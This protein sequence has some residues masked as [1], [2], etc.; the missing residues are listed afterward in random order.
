M[1]QQ[2]SPNALT[3]RMFS[4]KTLGQYMTPDHVADFIAAQL[5]PDLE[6]V[7]DLAAG[8]CALLAAVLAR[9]PATRVCGFE[10]D[11]RIFAASMDAFPDANLINGDGL[12]T[13]LRKFKLTSQRIAVVGNPPFTEITPPPSACS[14]VREAFPRTA[15][16][17]GAKR[18]ELYFLA[19]SLLIAKPSKGS[20]AIVMPAG[21]AD[22]DICTQ[23]RRSL[24]KNYAVRRAIEFPAQ[25]FTATEARAILLVIDT[26]EA[27]S[28]DI[29]IG[30]YDLQKRKQI[31]IYRGQLEPGE[32]LDARFHEGRLCVPQN[33]PTIADMGVTVVRGRVSRKEA[34]DLKL[35]VVH[36]SNLRKATSG[37]LHLPAQKTECISVGMEPIIAQ[38]GD[39]LL[40]RTGSR[41]NWK[42]V[43]IQS[44][45]SAIT[46]HVFRIRI[47]QRARRAVLASLRHPKFS[48]WLES[49][50]KGVCATVLTKRELL[51]M[52]LFSVTDN[53]RPA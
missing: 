9:S 10:I 23:Y 37:S 4:R 12:T 30:R 24:M 20:V 52:P 51:S 7:I 2:H 32:R 6:V 41:V 19:R 15:G 17:L 16:K 26:S 44:G 34:A 11:P 5:P 38:T 3:P 53:G 25:T 42:P 33:A 47:P 35:D 21:F 31:T 49:I 50:S 13:P 8:D 22:G 43:V 39:V 14:I 29:E 27:G 18:A 45:S 40:S 28:T 48:S 46:D 1:L 36:T